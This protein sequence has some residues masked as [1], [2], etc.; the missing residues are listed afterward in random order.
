MSKVILITGPIGSGKSEVCSY[1]SSKGYPVYD[2]DSRAK[3]LYDSVPGL[4]ERVENAIGLPF[5]QIGKIFTDPAKRRALEDV[6][7]PEL[8]SDFSAWKKA[9]NS[10]LIFVESAIALE[11][12]QFSDTYD[13]VWLVKAPLAT[14]LQRNPK[15]AERDPLQAPIDESLADIIIDNNSSIEELH[16]KI[17]KIIMD[18]EKTDLSKILAVSG[19]SGLYRFLVLSRGNAVIAES[20]SDKK[21]T[22]FDAHSKI[23]TLADIAIYTSEGELKLQE[24]FL[25][26]QK[27]LDGKEA[28]SSKDA[29]AVKALF[30]KAVPNYDPDRFYASHMKK[31]LDWYKEIALYASLDFVVEEEEVKEE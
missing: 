31:I 20:L 23:T 9:Q 19:K 29:D 1:L 17:D 12:P 7:Y 2:S 30:S 24:V 5:A 3:A 8:L 6:V 4:K 18:K 11:K 26:L 25:A 14:R 13:S 28:P 16:K 15:T 10:P 22:I 21:R 27:A